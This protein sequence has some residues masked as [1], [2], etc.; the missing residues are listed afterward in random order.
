MLQRI[1]SF[2]VMAFL[3]MPLQAEDWREKADS[4]IL[5]LENETSDTSKLELCLDINTIL[6]SN[7][8]V[9]A[10]SYAVEARILA[11]ELHDTR[12]IA[13]SIL[14]HCDFYSMI[15]EYT[16]SLEMAY[17]AIQ[18]GAVGV[19]MGRNIFQS[20]DPVAMIQ[21]VK[22]VVHEDATPKEALDLF[23]SLKGMTEE[24]NKA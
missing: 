1:F 4:L 24:E 2:A 3:F 19:D 15:G 12:S 18:A 23:T 9:E 6:K 10:F 14:K 21:A 22:A 7:K 5:L 17:N 13:F 20:D 11:E 16:T 8:P